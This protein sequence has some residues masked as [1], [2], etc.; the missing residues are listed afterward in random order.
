MLES[1]LFT[2]RGE[3]LVPLASSGQRPGMLVNILQCTGQAPTTKN[4]LVQNVTSA[5]VENPRVS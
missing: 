1:F 4:S 2:T 5:K 3:G